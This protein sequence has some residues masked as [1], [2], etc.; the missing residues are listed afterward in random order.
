[1]NFPFYPLYAIFIVWLLFLQ[2]I[3]K[4]VTLMEELRSR[5]TDMAD[6]IGLNMVRL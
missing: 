1:L 2:P 3:N 5:L 4:G 6:R